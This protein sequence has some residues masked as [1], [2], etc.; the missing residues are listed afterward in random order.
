MVLRARN[1]WL[2]HNHLINQQLSRFE[3]LGNR[4][5]WYLQTAELLRWTLQ[6][7]R[8]AILVDKLEHRCLLLGRGQVEK[9]YSASLSRN[10]QAQK[11]QEQDAATPRE[12]TKSCA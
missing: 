8:R 2:N 9:S 3:D 5:Q 11:V 6:S 7:G 1:A 4:Q 10:W 12:S